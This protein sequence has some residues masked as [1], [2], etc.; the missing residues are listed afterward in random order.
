M[1]TRPPPKPVKP[2]PFEPSGPLAATLAIEA[3]EA[4]MLLRDLL[5]LSAKHDPFAETK[6]SRRDAEWFAEQIGRF[7]PTGRIHLRG[8]YYRIL[9]GDVLLPDGSRFV[10]TDKTADADGGAA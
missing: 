9:A 7:L 2:P 8:S 10:G 3:E 6:A 1:H 5:V 4:G